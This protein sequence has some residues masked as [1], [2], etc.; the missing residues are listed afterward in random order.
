MTRGYLVLL[1]IGDSNAV[2]SNKTGKVVGG[3]IG[4]FVGVA[5][6]SM[7]VFVLFLRFR[8]M[9]GNLNLSALFLHVRTIKCNLD[10][11][12]VL[13]LQKNKKMYSLLL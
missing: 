5:L 9:K 7:L 6:L 12:T 13:A 8:K 4:G 11:G 2:D 10:F 1:S 3:S